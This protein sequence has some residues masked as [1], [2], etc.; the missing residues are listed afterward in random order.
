M[1]DQDAPT[2]RYA[3]PGLLFLVFA[4]Y[5]LVTGEM[6]VDKRHTVTITRADSPLIYWTTVLVTGALGLL[7]LRKAWQRIRGS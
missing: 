7:A 1:S 5:L 2:W 3:V 6:P 4:V